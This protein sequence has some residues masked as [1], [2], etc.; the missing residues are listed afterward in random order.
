MHGE[1][2]NKIW[3]FKIYTPAWRLNALG[4]SHSFDMMLNRAKILMRSNPFSLLAAFHV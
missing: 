4:C 1:I 3:T 2:F